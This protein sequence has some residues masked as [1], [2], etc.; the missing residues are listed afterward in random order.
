[1]RDCYHIMAEELHEVYPVVDGH[2]DLAGEI[3]IRNR[4]GERNVIKKRYM[5]YFREAGVRFVISSIFIETDWLPEKGM[6][7]A[8]HQISALL[9]EIESLDGEGVLVKNREDMDYV[10]RE[11]KLGFLLSLEGLDMMAEDCGT[12]RAFY[13]CGVRGASLTWSR[14]NYMGEGCC[15]A[16]ELRDVR[17]GLSQLGITAVRELERLH[18]FVDVSHLND[19]G[20]EDLMKVVTRPVVATHS[21]ARSVT[22]NYRNLTDDQIVRLSE[23]GGVIGLN[24]Y[25]KLVGSQPGEEAVIKMCSHILHISRLVGEGHMGFGLDLCDSYD[26]AAAGTEKTKQRGDCLRSHG[27]LVEIS[28]ELLREGMSEQNVCGVMGGNFIRFLEKIL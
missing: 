21:N 4:R 19:D 3:Y 9:E 5:P 8:M 24:A 11:R 6:Q 27:E 12:L 17:G 28:A 10:L 2:L 18:M 16:G 23:T 1:M 25:R 20:F 22:M 7:N 13:E 15:K 14:R 26:R